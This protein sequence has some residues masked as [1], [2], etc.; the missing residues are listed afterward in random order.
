MPGPGSE[1]IGQEEIR[2]VLEVLEGGWLFRYGSDEDP[3][4]KAKVRTLESD[5]EQVVGT[6]HALAVN[7]G[8]SAL[9]VALLGNGI[10][11][12][13][14][15][16]VPGYTFVAS[17]SSVAFARAV[18]VLAEIDET[19]NLDPR[20]VLR[21]IT[22][23]TK[24]IMAVDMLGNVAKMEELTAIAK[25][26]GLLLI[27]DAAQAFGASYHGR[28]AGSLGD[29]GVY[30]FNFYKTITA[31]D[32]G[33]IVTND[34]DAYQRYFALHDQGHSPLR[35]GVE[36][37]QRPF[38]GLDFRMTELTAAVLLAQL[39]KL[40]LIRERLRSK[41]ALFKSL[42]EDVPGISFRTITDPDG[43]LAT[44]LTVFF[45]TERVAREVASE[46][47]TKVVADSGWHVYSNME[48]LL[49][50]RMISDTGCPFNCPSFPTDY[51]YSKGM[52]PRTDAILG[53]AINIGIGIV[54]PGIGAGFGTAISD[55]ED[56]L[57]RKAD[58]FSH[59][60]SRHLT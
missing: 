19:L 24:A 31:G 16:I 35:Q 32:G 49:Q 53:R 40:T 29:V 43:E 52:L 7:S 50:R 23:R 44:F 57:R 38:M 21:R 13:D 22:V 15:V 46:L 1:L 56:T 11:P 18:P 47:G 3:N 34:E 26:H 60:A 45:P 55:S 6:R 27:E 17:M 12:G 54:D 10:G 51:R 58:R 8:S 42:I 37:G 30:S 9:L 36:I 4:Y 5:V 48:H 41:K 59:V 33:M 2:E 20:D 14:E 25:S 28:A 39:R